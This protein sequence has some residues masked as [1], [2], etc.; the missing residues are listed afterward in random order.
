MKYFV[1]LANASTNLNNDKDSP[2]SLIIM[3]FLFGII[4]Y[5]IIFRPQ[6]KKS[7]EHERLMDS[8]IPGDEILTK[9]GLIGK[10][11]R[12]CNN[13]DYLIVKLSDSNKIFL[14]K[15]FITSVLPKG[16]MDSI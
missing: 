7:K 4:F 9:G 5:L 10:V 16:T 2:Y 14:H 11:D 6:Q 15:N 12:T 8:I 1:T 13:S 3:L